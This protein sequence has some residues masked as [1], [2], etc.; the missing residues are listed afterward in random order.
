MTKEEK[1]DLI[2]MDLSLPEVDGWIATKC[3]N[4]DQE[5]NHIPI[6]ARM[7]HTLPGDRKRVGFWIRWLSFG[8]HLSSCL[9]T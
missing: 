9:Q 8:A 7:A 2:L 4:P 1:F 6:A 5:T 3:I